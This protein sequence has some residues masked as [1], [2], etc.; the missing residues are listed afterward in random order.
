MPL[1][2]IVAANSEDAKQL[3]HALEARGF[4]VLVSLPGEAAG[5]TADFEIALQGLSPE[6]ALRTA[7]EMASYEDIAVLIAPGAIV[8]AP[9]AMKVIPLTLQPEAELPAVE[10]ITRLPE[11][12]LASV[13][14]GAPANSE[15]TGES[16]RLEVLANIQAL[17]ETA[18]PSPVSLSELA[19]PV[20]PVFAQTEQVPEPVVPDAVCET[21]AFATEEP[22]PELESIRL[23]LENVISDLEPGS[24]VSEDEQPVAAE[25]YAAGEPVDEPVS[26]WPIWQAEPLA[27]EAHALEE[28]VIL[29]TTPQAEES[30]TA[31]RWVASAATLAYQAVRV[32]LNGNRNQNERVFWRTATVAA[33]IAISA[34]V[35][36]ASYHRVSPLPAAMMDGASRVRPVGPV[37]LPVRMPESHGQIKSIPVRVA[38]SGPVLKSASSRQR[39]P[40]SGTAASKTETDMVAP[41][42]VVRYNKR[43][44]PTPLQPPKRVISSTHHSSD[45]DV[46][47]EDTVTHFEKLPT[48][49]GGQP[50]R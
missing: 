19:V 5:Q 39:D 12:D 24:S 31:K 47:A 41:D 17:A 7:A 21:A 34:L 45:S 48:T 28:V 25:F 43:P 11:L 33:G 26:D 9:V 1:V 38:P 10:A 35:L 44:L 22:G 4:D 14:S 30:I 29:D 16:S 2:N 36:G 49:P 6:E 23:E 40:V 46:V 15:A 13:G 18:Q 50:R 37:S 42:T 8:D 3:Q 32:H 20:A 27:N